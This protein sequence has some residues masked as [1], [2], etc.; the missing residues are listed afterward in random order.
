MLYEIHVDQ[1]TQVQVRFYRNFVSES[2]HKYI[3]IILH[4]VNDYTTSLK[5]MCM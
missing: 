1:Y 4:N 5:K 2:K 3:N